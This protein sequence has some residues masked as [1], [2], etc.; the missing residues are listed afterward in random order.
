[1]LV[2]VLV[3]LVLQ[4]ETVQLGPRCSLALCLGLLCKLRLKLR[5]GQR[6]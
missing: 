5:K 4:R 1:V 6:L 3:L 2:L